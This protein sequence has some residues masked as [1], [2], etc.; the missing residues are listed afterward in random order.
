M[1]NLNAKKTNETGT[2]IIAVVA[3]LILAAV[4]ASGCSTPP[5]QGSVNRN[6]LPAVSYTNCVQVMTNYGLQN[7]CY[8][9]GTQNANSYSQYTY[10]RTGYAKAVSEEAKQESY[11]AY[12]ASLEPAALSELNAQWDA[13]AASVAK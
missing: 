9:T 10:T 6:D 3:A 1:D 11:K 13:L 12:L 8:A 7:Q 2:Q 5:V 4:L